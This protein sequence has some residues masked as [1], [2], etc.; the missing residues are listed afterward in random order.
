MIIITIIIC[1]QTSL[2]ELKLPLR[3]KWRRGKN[4]MPIGKC[5]YP[6]KDRDV[7]GEGVEP[8]RPDGQKVMVYEPKQ[9]SW[10]SLPPYTCRYFSMAIVDDQ[11]ALVGG[12]EIGYHNVT[13]KLGVWNE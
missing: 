6:L 12:L 10:D 5:G 13:N 4:I 9:D 8:H 7:Q 3:L 11:L 1:L 2:A